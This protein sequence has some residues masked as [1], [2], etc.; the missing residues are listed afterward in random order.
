MPYSD[1]FIIG[2][3]LAERRKRYQDSLV[4]IKPQTMT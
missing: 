3:E 2:I 4:I 1:Y